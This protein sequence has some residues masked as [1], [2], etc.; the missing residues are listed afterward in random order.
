MTKTEFQRGYLH[1]ARNVLGLEAQDWPTSALPSIRK[2]MAQV[3]V[4]RAAAPTAE[5]VELC[6]GKK[7]A[8]K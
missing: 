1:C 6:L 8:A 3:R 2:L 5:K 7:G 4:M